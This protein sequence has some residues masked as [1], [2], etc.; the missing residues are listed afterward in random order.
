MNERPS[1]SAES[2]DEPLL[3]PESLRDRED[4]EF[5]D[6]PSVEHQD[7]FEVY[8]PVEGMVIV[9]VTDDDGA[10]LVAY[11]ESVPVW[12][13]P[14]ATV[15]RDEDWAAVARREIESQTGVEIEIDGIELVR[16]KRYRSEDDRQTTGY[17][18]V[19]RASPAA[20]ETP[21][22]NVDVVGEHDWDFG[23]FEE[24]PEG[25]NEAGSD[26]EDDLRLFVD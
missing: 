15:E 4:V 1:A 23:W 3:D 20:D 6:K 19:F 10:V 16:R 7:H 14:H 5:L 17:D 24:V 22:E 8:E 18:V 9:G 11:D 25:D 2:D 26:V 21:S 13:L 12:L